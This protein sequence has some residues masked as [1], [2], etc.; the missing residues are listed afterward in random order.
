MNTSNNGNSLL[1]NLT[2]IV[3]SLSN[4]EKKLIKSSLEKGKQDSNH[5][6]TF[7]LID[8]SKDIILLFQNLNDELKFKKDLA[9]SYEISESALA[10]RFENL[11]AKIIKI[12]TE[13]YRRS[14]FKNWQIE[15]EK[16]LLKIEALSQRENYSQAADLL[17]KL[18]RKILP[19]EEFHKSI[20]DD[21]NI[22]LR[23]AHLK[24]ALSNWADFLNPTDQDEL[25]NLLLMSAEYIYGKPILKENIH[26]FK[27]NQFIGN[28]ILASYFIQQQ[29]FEIAKK[30]ISRA[31]DHLRNNDEIDEDEF[32]ICITYLEA[33]SGFF[34]IKTKGKLSRKIID[35]YK[36]NDLTFIKMLFDLLIDDAR[37]LSLLNNSNSSREKDFEFITTK[38][39]YTP[40]IIKEYP[41]RKEINYCVA[42]LISGDSENCLKTINYIRKEGIIKNKK[43]PLKLKVELLNLLASIKNGLFELGTIVRRIVVILKEMEPNQEFKFEKQSLELFK[44]FI[45]KTESGRKEFYN[46]FEKEVNELEASQH[47]YDPIHALII[48]LFRKGI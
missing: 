1:T 40:N 23:M 9:Q 10:K 19:K 12:I 30:K 24:I 35:L 11:Y 5:S 47:I 31:E 27:E 13:E 18:E 8:E 36:T 2:E 20:F 16:D 21:I 32:D 33:L 41:I 17:L 48:K 37:A 39:Q 45:K 4:K 43:N 22:Y 26:N 46:E 44:K 29:E 3:S 7:K 38:Y 34:E 15:A 28:K 14:N 42:T 25:L 6:K